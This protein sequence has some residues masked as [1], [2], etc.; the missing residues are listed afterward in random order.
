MH[1]LILSLAGFLL[2][3]SL[4]LSD[5]RVYLNE[6]FLAPSVEINCSRPA[7]WAW[8][9]KRDGWMCLCVQIM[10]YSSCLYSLDVLYR[11]YEG[12]FCQLFVC[13]FCIDIIFVFP[14][15]GFVLSKARIF[16]FTQSSFPPFWERFCHVF[17]SHFAFCLFI[18]LFSA[19]SSH[20]VSPLH[21]HTHTHT[22]V[23]RCGGC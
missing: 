13:C 1:I 5:T 6:S 14:S 21:A 7:R 11:K 16:P 18:F 10:F 4:S 8:Y 15:V 20:C 22:F 23:V 9:I 19:S 12:L 17:P 2:S 3:Q